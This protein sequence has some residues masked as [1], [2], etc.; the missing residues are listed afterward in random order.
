MAEPTLLTVPLA[1]LASRA[2]VAGAVPA[3]SETPRTRTSSNANRSDSAPVS[4]G[5]HTSW[6]CAV[7]NSRTVTVI[8]WVAASSRPNSRYGTWFNLPNATISLA[9]GATNSGPGDQRSTGWSGASRSTTRP[10]KAMANAVFA[11]SASLRLLRKGT[12]AT[13]GGCDDTIGSNTA[14][15]HSAPRS[16]HGTGGG[17][18]G[19]WATT[20]LAAP[21]TATEIASVRAARGMRMIISPDTLR[22]PQRPR[23]W[24][25][26]RAA[27]APPY[28]RRRPTIPDQQA[29]M[30][31]ND[32]RDRARDA[33]D[34]NR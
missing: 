22:G 1:R 8:P 33:T 13:R 2:D 17:T 23:R 12:T 5:F 19:Y 30:D 7:S 14:A 3:W 28:V 20:R 16:W 34:R 4:T 25:P 6:P 27:A 29:S 9:D 15:S 32:S 10:A 18:F 24:L 21:V 11:L 26:R 31:E